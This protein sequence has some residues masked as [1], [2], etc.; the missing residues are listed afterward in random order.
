MQFLLALF[1]YMEFFLSKQFGTLP[2]N[3]RILKSALKEYKAPMAK[4]FLLQPKGVTLNLCR[5]PYPYLPEQGESTHSRELVANHL[6]HP[7]HVSCETVLSQTGVIPERVNPINSS[8]R[9]RSK[10]I[11]NAKR[12]YNGGLLQQ[13]RFLRRNMPS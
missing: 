6:F 5:N 4:I 2:V 12:L 9:K 10:V 13:S 3:T 8:S 11:D 7:T 1:D